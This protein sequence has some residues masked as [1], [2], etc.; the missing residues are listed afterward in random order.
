MNPYTFVPGDLCKYL[1]RV[2]LILTEPAYNTDG[3]WVQAVETD[4]NTFR[5]I[6]CDALKLIQRAKENIN[7]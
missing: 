7:E 5:K 6:R 4:D 3:W 1:S 2:V